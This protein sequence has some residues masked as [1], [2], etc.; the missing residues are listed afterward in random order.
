MNKKILSL[1][2]VCGVAV[3]QTEK[4]QCVLNINEYKFFT[5]K[6]GTG[7]Y[8]D[9]H[10]GHNIDHRTRVEASAIEPISVAQVPIDDK[11]WVFF[12][13]KIITSIPLT[14]TDYNI[15]TCKSLVLARYNIEMKNKDLR[16]YSGEM[17][18]K[19]DE[20]TVKHEF[21]YAEVAAF[22]KNNNYEPYQENII[23]D[24][25]IEGAAESLQYVPQRDESVYTRLI[26]NRGGYPCLANLVAGTQIYSQLTVLKNQE[27]CVDVAL[28]FGN[29]VFTRIRADYSRHLKAVGK[30]END[31]SNI[32]LKVRYYDPANHIVNY[33]YTPTSSIKKLEVSDGKV[34]WINPTK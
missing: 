33:R 15:Q 31:F 25:G 4:A 30:P 2:F 29:K 1:V 12:R 9:V 26:G 7:Y 3:S 8:L 5:M 34:T 20:T 24:A 22:K 23:N 13:K 21:N 10:N 16:L 27:V 19:F 6:M 17:S 18:Y 32:S 28:D 14:V 11:K